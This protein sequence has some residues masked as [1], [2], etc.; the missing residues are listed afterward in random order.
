M[1]PP[2]GDEHPTGMGKLRPGSGAGKGERARA[3]GCPA[4][5]YAGVKGKSRGLHCCELGLRLKRLRH[6]RRGR[7]SGLRQDGGL[8]GHGGRR[9]EHALRLQG[10]PGLHRGWQ[11]LGR[12]HRG[13]NH[14]VEDGGDCKETERA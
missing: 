8:A 9:G 12:L 3:W 2:E 5:Y 7:C 14:R 10:G 4:P 13:R 11:R 1:R 6:G